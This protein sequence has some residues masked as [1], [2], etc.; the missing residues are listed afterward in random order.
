MSEWPCAPPG[1]LPYPGIKPASLALQEDSLPL[2][3]W[4]S[5]SIGVYASFSIRIFSGYI[6]SSGISELY[7]TFI[8]SF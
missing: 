8:S 6:P 2:Y 4:G 1:D 3:H 7:V 5:L